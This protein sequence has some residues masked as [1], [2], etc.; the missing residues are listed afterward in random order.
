MVWQAVW[1]E[2]NRIQFNTNDY[3][4]PLLPLYKAL[5]NDFNGF[6]VRTHNMPKVAKLLSYY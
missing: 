2:H 3:I 5:C 1:H 4:E 6:L